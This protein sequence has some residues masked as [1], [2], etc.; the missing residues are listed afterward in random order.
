[1]KATL[2]EDGSILRITV[3]DEERQLLQEE[4]QNNED[5][6]SDN[7]M[8][9]LFETLIG[10]SEYE[11]VGPEV[12]GDLT[13]APILGIWGEEIEVGDEIQ[14]E[15]GSGWRITGANGKKR[16]GQQIQNRWGFMAYQITSVQS[17]LA[18]KG[19]AVFIS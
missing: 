9:D 16:F 13:S 4:K 19:V 6:E 14:E 5:F 11:W 15:I 7:F 12:V 17:E 3:D 2:N 18:E 1:M 8:H 10:N